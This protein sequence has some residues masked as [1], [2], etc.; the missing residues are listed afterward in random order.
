M[1]EVRGWEDKSF[2]YSSFLT[3]TSPSLGEAL[4]SPSTCTDQMLVAS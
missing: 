2:H 1:R 3:V 4:Q